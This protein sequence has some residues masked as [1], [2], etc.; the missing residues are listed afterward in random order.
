[1]DA[2]LLNAGRALDAAM[3]L[4]PPEMKSD[5]SRVLLL[6]IGRQESRLIER[7]QIVAGRPT[8]PAVGL[9]QMEEGGGIKGVLEHRATQLHADK[10]CEA[11]GVAPLRHSVWEAM[12]RDDI[13][14]FA[15]GRLL[16][17][18]DVPPLPSLGD[19]EKNWQVYLRV[20]R[21]GAF[22]WD[23]DG[24]RKKWDASYAYAMQVLE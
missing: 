19:T 23:P 15:F 13:L 14:S 18:T 16:L 8:G 24:L 12:Q 7:R 21:P 11:R 6:A 2:P 20:W 3:Q 17:W 10:V 9:L 4:L 1:M 22:K 5:R